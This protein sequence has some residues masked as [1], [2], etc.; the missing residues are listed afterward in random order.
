M[1]FK[2]TDIYSRTWAAGWQ[3][4][5]SGLTLL[6]V[7]IGLLSSCATFAPKGQSPLCDSEPQYL[8][9]ADS[10]D[11]MVVDIY[12][13]WKSGER[14]GRYYLVRDINKETP[15]DGVRVRVP[16]QSL[17]VTSATQLGFLHALGATDCITAM[18]MPDRIYNRPEQ[19]LVDIGEDFNLSVEKLLLCQPELLLMTS[20]GAPMTNV[21]RIRAAGI[22]VLELVEWV[23][24]DPLA[25][26]AWIRL[27]GALTCRMDLADSIWSEVKEEYGKWTCSADTQDEENNRVSLA[28]GQNYRGTWYVPSGATYMGRLIHDAGAE[29]CFAQDTTK[30]SIPLQM[31]QALARFSEADV[32]IGVN[33]ESLDELALIDEKHTW[34]KAYQSARVYNFSR[35][36]TTAGGNDFW[37]TGIVHPEYILRDI[38]WA[39]DSTKMAGYEPVFIQKLPKK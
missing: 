3:R 30:A 29:Y 6:M 31:E 20:Y 9:I 34:M 21:E 24:Q 10:A 23:E 38:R 35:R 13:P 32:W 16:V 25:R 15:A 18:S 5:G 14:M 17:A 37:E 26:A 27:Y 19:T 28:T 12:S 2:R 22:Q 33:A 8:M 36:T 11:Y 39:M 4:V 1:A 7:L